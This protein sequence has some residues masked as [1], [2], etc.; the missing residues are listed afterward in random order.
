MT[1]LT[2]ALLTVSLALLGSAAIWTST[3]SAGT[4]WVGDCKYIQATA[5]APWN[6]F[7]IWSG[8][9][10][11]TA[12]PSLSAFNTTDRVC[13]GPGTPDPARYS[14]IRTK[15]GR[16]YSSGD[17]ITV[18]YSVDGNLRFIGLR[19]YVVAREPRPGFITDI[20]LI[21]SGGALPVSVPQREFTDF[22]LPAGQGRNVFR[23]YLKCVSATCSASPY[24]GYVTLSDIMLYVEDTEPP[25][26]TWGGP[27]RSGTNSGTKPIQLIGLDS[28]SG[29]HQL[30]LYV[31][32]VQVNSFV[33]PGC[34]TT[35][36]SSYAPCT[37]PFSKSIDVD[38]TASPWVNGA[39]TVK[40]CVYDFA[41]TLPTSSATKPAN[42]SC[43]TGTANI[44][45]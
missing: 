8:R 39:N 45:N 16:A 25:I 15:V 28:D 10:Q 1:R 3:S 36:H 7:P 21:N 13:Q 29:V 42:V 30:R 44:S 27:L 17:I 40:L 24:V 22:L 14:V 6:S 26:P 11:V 20:Q 33:N 31:N 9:Q 32:N 35:S 5:P 2:R 4:Y 19:H 12:T 38:T 23:G 43:D 41:E 34:D 18:R 37:T